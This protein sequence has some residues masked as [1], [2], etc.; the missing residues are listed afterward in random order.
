MVGRHIFI[1]LSKPNTVT[2]D[3][4]KKMAERPIIFSLA[5]PVPEIMPEDAHEAGAFI[6]ATGRS[7]YPNQLN[8]SLIFP[9]IFR[10]V[11][12]NNVPQFTTEMFTAAAHALASHVKG[13][14]PTNILPTMFDEDLV[15][16][17]A[18]ATK[19]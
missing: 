16:V 4:V 12:N 14:S 5:N 19:G 1:G 9:G 6:V 3:M 11:L 7:D 15:G 8:N 18:R 2:K 10:G 17:I 13:L